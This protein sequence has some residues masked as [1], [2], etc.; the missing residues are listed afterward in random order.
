MS[1]RQKEKE[2]QQ[3]Q[4]AKKKDADNDDSARETLGSSLAQAFT[5]RM[6]TMS[7]EELKSIPQRNTAEA[8]GKAIEE[9]LY[10]AFGK[11]TTQKYRNRGRSILFNVRL[12]DMLEHQHRAT[13]NI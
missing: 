8:M 1:A 4:S 3:A 5:S 6:Q 2:S 9:E 13:K 11:M 12:V 10:L 7:P